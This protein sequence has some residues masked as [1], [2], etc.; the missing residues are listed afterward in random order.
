LNI[1][2]NTK[3]KLQKTNGFIDKQWNIR[4]GGTWK[5][6]VAYSQ[7]TITSMDYNTSILRA[8]ASRTSNPWSVASRRIITVL[9]AQR[10]KDK[11]GE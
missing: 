1:G 9:E 3:K 6:A 11:V 4:N 7:H 8:R 10:W 2:F 5:P